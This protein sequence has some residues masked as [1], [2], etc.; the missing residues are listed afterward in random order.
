MRKQVERIKENIVEAKE[1]LNGYE[2][3][4]KEAVN[5]TKK[6]ADEDEVICKHEDELVSEERKISEERNRLRERERLIGQAMEGRLRVLENLRSNM[7]DEAWRWDL[8]MFIFGSKSDEA[9]LTDPRH[10]WKL[11]STVI[12]PEQVNA[13]LF[14]TTLSENMKRFGFTRFAADLF[15]AP[16]VVKQYLCNVSRLHQVPIGSAKT[17]DAYEEIKTA[18]SN[19]QFRLYL[20]D[21]HRVQFTVSKYSHEVLGQQSE[22][23]K[24]AKIFV[25]HSSNFDETKTLE[26]DK[27]ELK[28]KVLLTCIH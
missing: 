10:K 25:A 12:P 5:E 11:N 20:T 22:L 24:P 7:A 28:K 26:K 9:I 27:Q 3:F 15:T 8:P 17:N 4:R 16:D 13:A 18:F 14:T 6:Y 21:K 23:R 1:N 2:E 19:T